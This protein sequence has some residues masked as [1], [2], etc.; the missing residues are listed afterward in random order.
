M[1]GTSL[2]NSLTTIL[3]FDIGLK[4]TGVASGQTLT[5][6]A[7]PAGQLQANNGQLDWQALDKLLDEWQP[8][9]IVVGDPKTTDPRL[10][11][12]INRFKSH[13]QQQHKIPIIDIDETLTSS[14]ANQELQHSGL[15]TDKKTELR[16]QIA[17]CLIL[18]S[19]FN[20]LA[21]NNKQDNDLR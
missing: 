2:G 20:Q 19:Y 17:A 18:E 15:K 11:K 14:A 7:Q 1:K 16:D 21:F 3:A 13:I 5:N 9:L 8:N 6:S 12:L 10:N 4:R